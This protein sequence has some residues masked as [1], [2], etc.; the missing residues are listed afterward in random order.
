MPKVIITRGL[1][2]SGK[3]TKAK[4]WV[5]EDPLHR[6][7][8]N[9]DD[10]RQMVHNGFLD[11]QNTE[12]TI[13]RMRD[14]LITT[15]LKL[16]LDVINDDTNLPNRTVRDLRA[17]AQRNGAE[18]EVWDMTDVPIEVCIERDAQRE[19]TVGEA[20]IRKMYTKIQGKPYPIPII[21]PKN[22]EIVAGAPYVPPIGG[23]IP[24]AVIVDIDGTVAH[25]V[26]RS[27]YDESRVH[28]DLPNKPVID[29]VQRLHRDGTKII[30][31]SGR[32]DSCYKPTYEWILKHVKIDD[33][34]LFMRRTGD[35]RKDWVVKREIFNKHIRLARV[36]IIGV[37]D[38]RNQVVEMWRKLG[39]TVYQVAEGDF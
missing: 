32:T 8:V 21:E 25:M 14:A 38:D 3:T 33:F 5:A 16:G 15:A 9:R 4:A 13:T 19:K 20:V 12:K 30:F 24:E 26:S 11:G 29:M 35:N 1:P 34:A 23:N 7:R 18:F 28:E 37:F 31:C 2:A 27:P 22:D 39:L 6:T 17:I 36:N 10:L